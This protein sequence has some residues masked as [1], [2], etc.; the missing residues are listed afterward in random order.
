MPAEKSHSRVRVCVGARVNFFL[1]FSRVFNDTQTWRVQIN[2]YQ[3]KASRSVSILA[4]NAHYVFSF[5]VFRVESS[6]PSCVGTSSI[7]QNRFVAFTSMSQDSFT[8]SHGKDSS[9]DGP[10]SND[11][12]RSSRQCVPWKDRVI[13]ASVRCSIRPRRRVI[14]AR[15][16]DR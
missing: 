9:L 10:T 6:L 2:A 8:L 13:F 15:F 16:F 14:H 12:C 11:Q 5:S 1:I 3:I 7:G 4:K